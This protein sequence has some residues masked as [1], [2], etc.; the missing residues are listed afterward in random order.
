MVN[1]LALQTILY[2]D[3]GHTATT[4]ICA[5]A[6]GNILEVPVS[7]EQAAIFLG[8]TYDG[9][10]DKEEPRVPQEEVVQA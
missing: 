8:G 3:D 7:D 6:R 10:V 4:L 1:L 2:F 9:V 5:D